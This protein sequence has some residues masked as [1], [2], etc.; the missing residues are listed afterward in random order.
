MKQVDRQALIAHEGFLRALARN[1]AFDEHR[2]DDLVQETWLAAVRHPPRAGR[3]L[4]SWLARVLHNAARQLARAEGRRARRERA[5]AR[6]EACAEPAERTRERIVD[7]VLSLPEPYR[8]TVMLRFFENLPPREVARRTGVPVETARTRLRRALARLRTQLGEEADGR[9]GMRFLSLLS[10]LHPRNVG[11]G[12]FAAMGVMA[13]KFKFVL[14]G[15]LVAAALAAGVAVRHLPGASK[16]IPAPRAP[17]HGAGVPAPDPEAPQDPL[18]GGRERLVASPPAH[19]APLRIRLL[20]DVLHPGTAKIE[21]RAARQEQ[22]VRGEADPG[23]ET[24]IDVAPLLAGAPDRLEIRA[25][26][27]AYMPTREVVSLRRADG[28]PTPPEEP[29]EVRLV[30][31]GSVTGTVV[32]PG[33]GPVEGAQVAAFALRDGHP[34]REFTERAATNASG[35]YRLRV[36]AD[37]HYLVA[38]VADGMLPGSIDSDLRVGSE[39]EAAVVF[40]TEG[41]EI[42]GRVTINGRA[43]DRDVSLMAEREE[44][45]GHFLSSGYLMW[46]EEGVF[47]TQLGAA[48][49]AK[50]AYRIRGLGAGTYEV[51]CFSVANAHNNVVE[52]IGSVV[53]DAPRSGAD[54]DVPLSELAFVVRKDGEPAPGID[55]F[56]S[57][58]GMDLHVTTDGDGRASYGVRPGAKYRVRVLPEGSY[59]GVERE[60]AG[61]AAGETREEI[62]ILEPVPER[63]TL[64]VRLIPVERGVEPPREG[65]F[66]F[67]RVDQK[68]D[69]PAFLREARAREDG[70]IPVTGVPAGTYRMA[71]RPGGP[72][73]GGTAHFL[74][75]ERSVVLPARG[76]APVA[77]EVA[78]GG[79]LRVTVRSPAGEDVSARGRILDASGE[80][81]P[82]RFYRRYLDGAVL[83]S[84]VGPGA[85]ELEHPLAPGAYRLEVR[86]PGFADTVR[87]VVMDAGVTT[88]VEIVLVPG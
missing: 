67:W 82:V 37:G 38:A 21:A 88:F 44:L 5:V 17:M 55:V 66:A 58:G 15:C 33:G 62:L 31:A 7:A 19:G 18:L 48:T 2:V 64:L 28:A 41:V 52:D 6:P 9:G 50:G 40:L 54:F 75:V 46:A 10:M 80:P 68:D 85:A 36:G 34:A 86:Y 73:L 13:M 23:A 20:A 83:G 39:I 11:V 1:L 74:P 3:G 14:V 25:D 78:R 77:L 32:G 79:R 71:V 87:E 26:H 65:A 16:S 45:L 42:S 70:V 24:D 47:R 59:L 60:V 29:V 56:I 69:W 53:V 30:L 4:R 49:D 76:E 27:P 84:N 57:H 72:W 12:A 81:L 43:P 8:T 35:R 51:R 61:P 22:A 63:A